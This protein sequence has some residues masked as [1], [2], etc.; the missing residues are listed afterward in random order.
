MR[1][2]AI[3]Q[4]TEERK[5][6]VKNIYNNI[7]NIASLQELVSDSSDGENLM[8]EFKAVIDDP[9]NDQSKGKLKSTIAKEICA[10]LN[11]NDGVLC[12]GVAN[13]KGLLEIKNGTSV[14]NLEDFVDRNLSGMIEPLP[15]NIALKT[16]RD[17]NGCFLVI[18]IPRSD[19]APHR[20]SSWKHIDRDVVRNYY[21][22]VGSQSLQM[23]EHL[24]KIMYLSDNRQINIDIKPMITEI[25]RDSIVIDHYV[26]PDA[27]KFISEYMVDLQIILLDKDFDCIFIDEITNKDG[28]IDIGNFYAKKK[29]IH[30]GQREYSINDFIIKKREEPLMLSAVL[31]ID[32]HNEYAEIPKNL[33]NRIYAIYV[34]SSF[35]CEG[36]PLKTNRNLFIYGFETYNS[37][38]NPEYLNYEF[39]DKFLPVEVR[40]RTTLK[41]SV[42]V[43]DIEKSQPFYNADQISLLKIKTVLSKI[44]E[45]DL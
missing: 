16:I 23:P 35:A 34:E 37:L 2:N 14:T 44:V 8:L 21:M 1:A 9:A 7:V 36:F 28:F 19:R 39:A 41:E 26:K 32:Y 22:R 17:D 6:S 15:S 11:S 4:L 31:N 13:N 18:F 33:F 29:P 27:F 38:T 45:R 25:T 3:P 42:F 30:P 20:V 43:D 40:V 5:M 24:I 10:F 12:L